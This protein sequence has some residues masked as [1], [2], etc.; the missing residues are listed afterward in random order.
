MAMARGTDWATA[1]PL[2]SSFLCV[3]RV[4]PEPRQ[5]CFPRHQPPIRR[6]SPSVISR[7]AWTGPILDSVIFRLS[8]QCR[9]FLHHRPYGV[10]RE[11]SSVELL[12]LSFD[13]RTVVGYEANW[14]SSLSL[15][16]CS[17]CLNLWI[18][19]PR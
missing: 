19:A 9:T 11:Q 13:A 5:A 15:G 2:P 18:G 7:S 12:L 6:T 10:P 17:V 16:V 1:A 14:K 4:Q 8:A 3:A